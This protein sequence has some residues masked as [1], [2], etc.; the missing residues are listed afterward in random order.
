MRVKQI[1]V[2][3]RIKKVSLINYSAKHLC[4]SVL[5]PLLA[6]LTLSVQANAHEEPS[7]A[8]PNARATAL[9]SVTTTYEQ[10]R[11]PN[12]PTVWTIE[13]VTVQGRSLLLSLAAVQPQD[14]LGLSVVVVDPPPEALLNQ[15]TARIQTTGNAQSS[16]NSPIKD[17]P[18]LTV[19][20]AAG[21]SMPHE[22]NMGAERPRTSGTDQQISPQIT[23]HLKS[24]SIRLADLE[25]TQAEIIKKLP[26]CGAGTRRAVAF[27]QPDAVKNL[28]N[29]SASRA[30]EWSQFGRAACLGWTGLPESQ[31]K[32][33]TQT[34]TQPL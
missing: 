5:V 23:L 30:R 9:P 4:H 20:T 22:P 16:E 21:P 10:L 24:T 2:Y 18:A 15:V 28:L 14:S 8:T 19:A 11:N 17:V 27:I 1:R 33:S 25:S 12:A 7:Q 29:I 32:N 26:K 31:V 13:H 6:P 3:R 34:A